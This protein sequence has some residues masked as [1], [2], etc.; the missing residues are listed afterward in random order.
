MKLFKKV[1]SLFIYQENVRQ[2]FQ[3]MFLF[4]EVIYIHL[5][6][7]QKCSAK[8]KKNIFE[9]YSLNVVF[10]WSRKRFSFSLRAKLSI[11]FNWQNGLRSLGIQARYFLLKACAGYF[12]LFLRDMYFFVSSNEVHWKE[13]Q[14]TLVFSSHCF[15]NIYSLLSY[16]ALPASLKLL[17]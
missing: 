17:V 13:I 2:E 15:T 14:L 5:S 6:V 8:L 12:L 9:I 4:R 16:H 10:F 1:K 11:W 7:K 3:S